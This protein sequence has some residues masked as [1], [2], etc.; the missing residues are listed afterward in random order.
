MQARLLLFALLASACVEAPVPGTDAGLGFDVDAS[1]PVS[2]PLELGRC[3]S[4]SGSPCIGSETDSRF[5]AM[6]PDA[7]MTPVIGPQGSLMVALAARTTGIAP[8]DP[9]QPASR[10]NPVLDITLFDESDA[11]ISRLFVRSGFVPSEG[12]PDTF[13][14]DQ[15]FV[16]IEASESLRDRQLTARGMLRDAD[17][18]LRCGSLAFRTPP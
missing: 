10:D 15:L 11:A 17:G 2:P 3:V 6:P 18:Q 5:E 12:L 1:C 13:E 4:V 9:T 7:M 8:G 14:S 16:V